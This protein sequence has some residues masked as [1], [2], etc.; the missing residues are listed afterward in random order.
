MNRFIILFLSLFIIDSISAQYMV[1]PSP[2]K[3]Y[4]IERALEL[5]KKDPKPLLIDVYTEGS[6]WC[7]YMMKT[8]FT[9]KGIASYINKNFYPIRLDAETLDTI[10][11]NGRKYFNRQIG[12]RPT[13]DLATYLLDNKLSYPSIVYFDRSGEKMVV[14]GFKEAKDI[15]P[16]LVY[17]VEDLA[18][19]VSLAEFTANFMYTYPE[20]FE[21]DHSI[22][23]IPRELKP[24]TLGK[25][26]WVKPESVTI[27]N[28]KR[29]KPTVVFFYTDWCIKC[30][31]MEETTFGNQDIS[32][33][34]NEYF[35]VIK[36]NAA[37]QEKLMFLGRW[38]KGAKENSPHEFVKALLKKDL[39]FPAVVFFDEQG[40]QVSKITTYMNVQSLDFIL[41]YFIDKK[42]KTISYNEYLKAADLTETKSSVN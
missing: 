28:R 9:N 16:I 26:N 7:H 1:S 32:D 12:H 19:N 13:H 34:L 6:S 29:R 11:F 22:F 37:S 5:N 41:H 36:L 40:K 17:Q 25:P 33:L 30:R 14:P 3:W 10:E 23:K 24:D 39:Q 42:Y 35:N 2:V 38:Y 21:K 4:N 8:T 15:E 27:K 18:D 31:V 20:A